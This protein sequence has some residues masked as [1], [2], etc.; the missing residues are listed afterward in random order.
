V[1][2]VTRERLRVVLRGVGSALLLVIIF[3]GVFCGLPY[4]F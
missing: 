4:S 2:P 1:K 3:Y